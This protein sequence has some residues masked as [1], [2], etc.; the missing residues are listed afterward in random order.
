MGFRQV[1]GTRDQFL[2]WES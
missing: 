2:T 1:V